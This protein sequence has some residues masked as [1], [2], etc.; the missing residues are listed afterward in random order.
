M[1]LLTVYWHVIIIIIIIIHVSVVV[2]VI[3]ALVDFT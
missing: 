3:K 2:V 1:H